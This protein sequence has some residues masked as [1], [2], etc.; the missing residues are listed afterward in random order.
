MLFFISILPVV[1][2]AIFVYRKDTFEKEPLRL[3]LKCFFFGCLSALPASML[4]GILQSAYP[5]SGSGII[6]GMFMGYVVAGSSEELFKLLMLWLAVWRSSYFDEYFDGIVYAAFVSLGFAG[7]ENLMY[8]FGQGD[9][10]SSVSTG[11]VRALVSVPGHFLFA[12]V[13]GY[14]FALAKFQPDQRGRHLL[15]AFLYPM[16][17]HGTFDALLMIP[18]YMGEEGAIIQM[19]ALPLFIF[20]DVKLWKIGMRKLNELQ[21]LNNEQNGGYDSWK[22]GYDD[23][24]G[25]HGNNGYSGANDDPFSGFKWDV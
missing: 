5:G 11:I 18:E 21:A 20:F 19:I 7:L 10:A 15:K 1:L 23:R 17:L 24:N 25:Y 12:V 9:F 16:L 4:E 22:T 14:Y 3:L 2:L 8:V 6:D 13:M